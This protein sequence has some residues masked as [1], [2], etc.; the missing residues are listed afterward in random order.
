MAQSFDEIAVEQLEYLKLNYR[1]SE[2]AEILDIHPSTIYRVFKDFN[3]EEFN[4]ATIATLVNFGL[5]VSSQTANTNKSHLN[6]TQMVV[7]PKLATQADLQVLEYIH[8]KYAVWLPVEVWHGVKDR[9]YELQCLITKYLD[10][11]ALSLFAVEELSTAPS[12]SEVYEQ[13]LL[14]TWCYSF[15][16]VVAAVSELRRLNVAA[17]SALSFTMLEV[18]DKR[19]CVL[20]AYDRDTM[21]DDDSEGRV[22]VNYANPIAYASN[23]APEHERD[24]NRF[25]HLLT[26][27]ALEAL[28]GVEKAF[29]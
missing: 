3:L 8:T 26:E 23:I 10:I 1:V 14:R 17:T 4:Y 16:A 29:N 9:V 12:L 19:A 5:S 11:W 20:L 6:L 13:K 18:E 27:L 2:L 25:I 21:V 28:R 7:S 22:A 15:D 24:F